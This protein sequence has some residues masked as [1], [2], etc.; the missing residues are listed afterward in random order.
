MYL[1]HYIICVP[2]SLT[3]PKMNEFGYV[4]III[5]NHCYY[6]LVICAN[7]KLN[8]FTLA[9]IDKH[10]IIILCC[11]KIGVFVKQ[12]RLSHMCIGINYTHIVHTNI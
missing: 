3:N 5:I 6:C 1:I 12:K 7:E 10:I 2:Q 9:Q 4:I 11:L 8:A